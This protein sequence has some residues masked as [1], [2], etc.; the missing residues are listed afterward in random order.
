MSKQIVLP[1]PLNKTK[2]ESVLLPSVTLGTES[3]A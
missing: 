2:P 3:V 1:D